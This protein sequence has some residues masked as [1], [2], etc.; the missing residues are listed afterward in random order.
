MHTYDPSTTLYACRHGQS[1]G[2]TARAEAEARGWLEL[3]TPFDDADFPLTDVG[4]HQARLLGRA[5][6]AMPSSQ[7]PT[8]IVSSPHRRALETAEGIVREG[9]AGARVAFSIDRRLTPKAFGVLERLTKRGVAE[10][11]PHLD[12]QRRQAGR[13]H[14][15]PP[16]GESRCDVVLRVRDVL[17]DLRKRGDGHRVLLVTHQVVINA[18]SYLLDGRADDPL[19]RDDDGHVPNARLCAFALAAPVDVGAAI[20]ER[21]AMA[22]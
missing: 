6:A 10:R 19:S 14:F 16:G 21:R 4:R 15:C 13:F 12:A 7:R 22:V 11:Y 5:I 20:D 2:N 8:R 9:Y 17:A 18:L 3:D 1:R